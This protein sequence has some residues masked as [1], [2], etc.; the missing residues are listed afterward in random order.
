MQNLIAKVREQKPLVQHITNFVTMND[1]ANITLAIGASP[2]MTH[3][4]GEAAE[5]ANLSSALVINMG[6]VN[7]NDISAM[8]TAALA[9]DKKGIPSIFDPVGAGASKLR[10]A[11][12]K[13][14]LAEGRFKILKGNIS[15]IRFLAGLSA[16]TKGVDASDADQKDSLQ[17][18]IE[19][20][21]K[22][23]LETRTVVAITGETDIITDGK[24]TYLVKNGNKT[25]GGAVSGTG[26]M[27]NSLIAAFCS[28]EKDYAK[29][30]ATA[31]ACMCVAGEIALE[32]TKD[33]GYG[34]FHIALHDEISKMNAFTF[35]DRVKIDEI[36]N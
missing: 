36:Q 22:L 16:S 29:A 4:E 11:S 31:I 21:K 35:S 7:E 12:A 8:L 6:T 30:A 3:D 10:N 28:V 23:A 27:C 9:A 2:I 5:I 17:D 24:K 34:S 1:C 32:N 20:A 25:L 14:L 26:C 33:K 13:K 19:M 15:E 18:N